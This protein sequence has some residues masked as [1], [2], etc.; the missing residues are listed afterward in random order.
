MANDRK[1]ADG[2]FARATAAIEGLRRGG[3]APEA[4]LA[5]A[6]IHAV[7]GE[8]NE[9]IALLKRLV[10]RPELPFAGWTLPIEPLFAPLRQTAGFQSVIATLAQHAR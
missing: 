6:S 4:C 2:A 3:R 10:D 7:K 8:N 5:E 9:A 1:G